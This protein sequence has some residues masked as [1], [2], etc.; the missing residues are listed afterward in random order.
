MEPMTPIELK[1]AGMIQMPFVQPKEEAMNF[2]PKTH[3]KEPMEDP[4]EQ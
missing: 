3:M 4:R 1:K 2:A